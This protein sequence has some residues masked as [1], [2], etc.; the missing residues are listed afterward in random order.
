VRGNTVFFSWYRDGIVAVDIAGVRNGKEPRTIAQWVTPGPNPHPIDS[1]LRP[2][3]GPSVWGVALDG[4][5]V[6]A[7]DRNSGLWVLRLER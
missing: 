7:S 6:L 1:R 3:D 5:L 4:D 2:Q